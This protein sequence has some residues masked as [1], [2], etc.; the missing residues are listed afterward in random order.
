MTEERDILK[1]PRPS[2]RSGTGKGSIHRRGEGPSF[3]ARGRLSRACPQ[4]VQAHDHERSRPA[5]SGE[6]AHRQKAA[7]PNPRWVGETTDFVIGE[8]GSCIWPRSSTVL[9]RFVVGWA[10]SAVN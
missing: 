3:D 2:S 1:K 9:S 5:G 4:A 8:S 6:S 7:P 10:V